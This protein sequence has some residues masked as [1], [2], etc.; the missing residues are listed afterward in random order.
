MG[1][2]IWLTSPAGALACGVLAWC[3]DPAAAPAGRATIAATLTL[4]AFLVAAV[5]GVLLAAVD[6]RCLRLPDLLVGPVLGAALLLLGA[7][8]AVTGTAGDLLRA[9]AAALALGA[10]YLVLA[11]IPG[12]NLGLGDVKLC[13]PLGCCSAG[14]VGRPCCSAPCFR[15]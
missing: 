13:L 1:P 4:V 2:P 14:W 15:T 11:L 7:A 8:A 6:M 12:A 5:A 10:G 3:I 9:L